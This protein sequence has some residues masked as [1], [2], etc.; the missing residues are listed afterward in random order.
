MCKKR[1]HFHNCLVGSVDI[2]DLAELTFI[3]NSLIIVLQLK[4]YNKMD[5]N[6][7]E[8]KTVCNLKFFTLCYFTQIVKVYSVFYMLC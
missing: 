4:Y 1:N 3:F 7:A 6:F 5:F 8:W 2:P